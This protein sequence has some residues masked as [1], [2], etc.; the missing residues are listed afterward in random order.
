MLS[1]EATNTNFSL[2]FDPT[3]AR[4][5]YLPHCTR[6]QYANYYA[7]DAVSKKI[8]IGYIISRDR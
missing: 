4:I 5:H 8:A 1:R 3:G 7:T 2:W 6:G